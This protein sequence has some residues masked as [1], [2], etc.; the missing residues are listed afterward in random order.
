[1]A[2]STDEQERRATRLRF[3]VEFGVIHDERHA[4]RNGWGRCDCGY[5]GPTHVGIL[6]CWYVSGS[7]RAFFV[8][9]GADVALCLIVEREEIVQPLDPLHARVIELSL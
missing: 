9:V 3:P 5:G 1:M 6:R 4:Y 8:R 2:R 7:G